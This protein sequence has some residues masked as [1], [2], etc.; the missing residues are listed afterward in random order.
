MSEN[1]DTSSS[2]LWKFILPSV[3]GVLLFMTPVPLDEGFTIPIAFLSGWIEGLL[4]E[5]LPA[6]MTVI[7][8]ISFAG[9]L[10]HKGFRP[11]KMDESPFIRRLFDVSPFWFFVRFAAVILSVLTLFQLGPEAI[12]SEDTGGLLLGE[13]LPLLF[14]I[15]LFAGLLLPLLLNFGL[16]EFVGSLLS[17]VMRPLFKLPGRASID[18]ITSWIGD[19][20]IGVLLTNQ[21]YE[22]GYYTKKEAAIVGTTFSVVSIMFSLVVIQYVDLGHMFFEFYFTVVAAGFVAALIMPR[23]PP[24]SLKSDDYIDGKTGK[25][26]ETVPAPYNQQRF[27]SVKYGFNLAKKRADKNTSAAAFFKDGGK[28]VLDMWLG[29][30]PVIMAI[31]TTAVIIASYTPFFTWIGMPF[32]PILELMQVPEAAAASETVMVGFADMFLPAVFASGIESEMTRFIIACLSIVQLIFLS[33]VGGVLLGTK[34]PIDFKDLFIIF[35]ERTIIALPVIVL[36]AHMI[37]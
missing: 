22:G 4:I 14:G 37:F 19:G 18:S 26:D 23:I 36:I 10:I 12:Y 21:Q 31:G 6:I 25:L 17:K 34:I 8:I 20:T 32:I 2:A 13:L 30:T 27:G 5:V 1:T 15:F 11:Y 9:S 33:E 29:V 3:I 35:L 16:L 24:L 7:I 28:N